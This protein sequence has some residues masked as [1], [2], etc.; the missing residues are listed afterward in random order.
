M[1]RV[2]VR[3]MT[4]SSEAPKSGM[5]KKLVYASVG[6]GGLYMLW[7]NPT[8]RSYVGAGERKA[9]AV[10]DK[11]SD[12]IA[13]KAHKVSNNSEKVVDKAAD[14]AENAKNTVANKADKAADKVADKAENAKNTVANKA[15]KAADKADKKV[16]EAGKN[17]AK[18]REEYNRAVDAHAKIAGKTKSD[19]DQKK[20]ADVLKKSEAENQKKGGD[21]AALKHKSDKQEKDHVPISAHE[22]KQIHAAKQP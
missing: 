21:T 10:K 22:G 5:I 7:Q 2:F 13:D 16:S 12:E 11:V 17:P 19:A 14:K 4:A 15:D 3:R 1:L 18:S 20:D 6:F 9:V 8:F